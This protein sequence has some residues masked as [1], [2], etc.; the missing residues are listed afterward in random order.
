M[1]AQLLHQTAVFL[2]EANSFLEEL[3]FAEEDRPAE[4]RVVQEIRFFP[5]HGPAGLWFDRSHL[6]AAVHAAARGKKAYKHGAIAALD[7]TRIR[8]SA[9]QENTH[10][11]WS[12][13][14]SPVCGV[15][16]PPNA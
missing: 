16:P 6:R 7:R 13:W 2:E 9:Q 4:H 15:R 10:G 3:L 12:D 1:V 8:R 11:I 14:Q 5:E